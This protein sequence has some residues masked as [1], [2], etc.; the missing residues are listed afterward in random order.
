[1]CSPDRVVRSGDMYA[2]VAQSKS[3]E[4]VSANVIALDQIAAPR[5]LDANVLIARNQ[6]PSSG[7]GSA[8][9]IIGST[10]KDA[11][12]ILQLCLAASVRANAV[13]LKDISLPVD[14]DAAYIVT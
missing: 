11:L 4:G 14:A 13:A 1:C 7:R 6:V 12:A 5:K 3:S 9:R 8:D 10:D 2:K